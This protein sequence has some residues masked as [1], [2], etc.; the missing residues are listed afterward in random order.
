[1][2]AL[3]VAGQ[4]VEVTV[5]AMVAVALVVAGWEAEAKVGATPEVVASAEAARAAE[6][7]GVAAAVK[8]EDV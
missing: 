6:A 8:A 7:M 3:A 4:V 2:V 5:E 1:M